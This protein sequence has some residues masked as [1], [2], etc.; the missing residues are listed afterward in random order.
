[1]SELE[2]WTPV[3]RTGKPEARQI[4]ERSGRVELH[5]P[6]S[7]SPPPE[8]TEYFEQ[9]IESRFDE[10]AP[11]PVVRR[12]AALIY[13]RLSQQE[14]QGWIG[15]VDDAIA[16]SNK[17]YAHVLAERERVAE[18]TEAAEDDLRGRLDEARRLLDEIPD[19]GGNLLSSDG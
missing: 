16:A 8:W 14:F 9:S 5:F 15:A 7:E 13:S 6:L 3:R 1:M 2:P 19:P 10:P 11:R 4:D 12:Q 17:Y 18:E